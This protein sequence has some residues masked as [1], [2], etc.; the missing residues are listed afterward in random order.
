MDA[1]WSQIIGQ[2]HRNEVLSELQNWFG[3]QI[4][5]G[6]SWQL[7]SDEF[8]VS[9]DSLALSQEG[10]AVATRALPSELLPGAW[11]PGRLPWRSSSAFARGGLW[12]PRMRACYFFIGEWI[13]RRKGR[14]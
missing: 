4:V 2:S 10:S 11:W 12:R 5:E 9:Q 8:L 6:L 14:E 13:A 7:I 3:I 1:G